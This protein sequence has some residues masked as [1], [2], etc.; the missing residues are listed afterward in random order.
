MSIFNSK[1]LVDRRVN[2]PLTIG[3]ERIL[4]IVSKS[5]SSVDGK[6]HM[7]YRV[8]TCFNHP[9]GGLSDFATLHGIGPLSLILQD[10]EAALHLSR[11]VGSSAGGPGGTWWDMVGHGGTWWDQGISCGIPNAH[12]GLNMEVS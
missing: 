11:R 9:F 12:D 2:V 5:E 8:S 6:H 1:R 10:D 4:W 7:V 3:L